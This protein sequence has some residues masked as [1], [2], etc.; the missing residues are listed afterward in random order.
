LL[1]N[2][3]RTVS[4]G[5]KSF[6]LR[7]RRVARGAARLA[8]AACLLAA[9][10]AVLAQ[11]AGPEKT[12]QMVRLE[13]AP[14][15]DGKLDEELW[16]RAAVVDD[17]YQIQPTEFSAASETMRVRVF[18]DDDA[19]YV[20]AE[21]H[22]SEP[23][24]VTANLLRQ[25]ELIA[26]E[27]EFVVILDP[28]NDGRSGYRFE[29]NPNGL[30]NDALYEDGTVTRWD[31]DG[32]WSA[33]AVRT[34][35]GWVAEMALPFKTLSFDPANDTWGI[36]FSRNIARKGERTGWVSRNRNQNAAIVG[37]AVGMNGMQQGRGLDVVP[38]VTVG[39]SRLYA[40]G[41][42]DTDTDPSLDVFYK[43]TPALNASLTINTDFSATEVDDRQVNLTR[44]GLFFPEKRDFFLKDSDL[45][46]FGRLTS[47]DDNAFSATTLH[48]GRPFFSRRIGLG[49]LGEAVD[50]KYGGKVSGRVGRF[51]I[52]TLAIRQD[53]YTN[54][55][56]NVR[57]APADLFVGRAAMGLLDESSVGL[58]VTRGDPRSNLDNEVYGADFRYLNTR[59][60]G[61]RAL[62]GE[63]WLQQS[64]TEDLDGDDGAAGFRLSAPN[65]TGWRGSIGVKELEQNF[66]PAL[67]Y[68][69]R[70]GIRDH[71]FEVG[72]TVRPEGRELI[73]VYAGLDVQSIDLVDGRL[74]SKVVGARLVELEN[75]SSDTLEVW[76]ERSEENLFEDFAIADG[77]V[78]PD[79]NYTFDRYGFEVG[80]GEYRRV[81]GAIGYA[82]GDF[83]GGKRTD[84][85]A[86]VLW[87]A[88]RHFQMSAGYE[89]NE[90]ELPAGDFTARIGKLGLNV[91][92]SKTLSWVNL[93]QYDNVSDTVGV[94]SRLHWIPQAGREAFLVLNHGLEEIGDDFHSAAADLSAK[95]S[96]TFRF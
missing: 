26:N 88:S 25:G 96:Y 52:G 13:A 47:T 63:V 80:S 60:P 57:V 38:S 59:L 20:G 58:I 53:E 54:A 5:T 95:I 16:S 66:N 69:D 56:A 85:G 39:R 67:G 86:D 55:N 24:Q 34:D 45:F 51:S 33:A 94:N 29:T 90:V 7:D 70:A 42:T 17:F 40:T 6:A 75:R 8:A 83:F 32:I 87:K 2:R 49:P 22:D 50:L 28:F 71:T 74:Q 73:S 79:G 81:S 91:V 12:L 68:V 11:S 46:E 41:A 1:A 92:F 78:I 44:F 93:V 62:Q 43:V 89:I 48:N 61:N 36:N 65:N 76:V 21:I 9:S 72:Y 10:S 18:Y 14:V 27:D 23:G 37:A 3:A 64:R 84:Y 15:V 35:D 30:R 19:L 77:I 31:W 4:T 82:A